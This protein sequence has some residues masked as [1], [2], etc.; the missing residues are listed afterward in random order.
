[1]VAADRSVRRHST[2]LSTAAK[3]AVVSFPES[4]LPPMGAAHA[5]AVRMANQAGGEV[6]KGGGGGG[7]DGR[8]DQEAG[9]RNGQAGRQAG[10][11]R[12][13]LCKRLLDLAPLTPVR[14]SHGVQVQTCSCSKP[15]MPVAG[16]WV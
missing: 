16:A 10:T 2:A 3:A 12:L 7:T 6:R 15:A 13:T 5:N 1:M 4:G 8:D 14:A 11:C 9:A